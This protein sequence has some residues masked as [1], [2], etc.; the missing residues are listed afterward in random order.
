[1]TGLLYFNEVV[2]YRHETSKLY[3]MEE[4]LDHM[5]ESEIRDVRLTLA[6]ETLMY[7]KEDALEQL[8]TVEEPTEEEYLQME[9][10]MEDIEKLRS[11]SI[12]YRYAY[13]NYQS[14]YYDLM[15]GVD[16]NDMGREYPY[17]TGKMVASV[18]V[19]GV[20]ALAALCIMLYLLS[21]YL[22]SEDELRMN[23]GY[24]V[25]TVKHG[26]ANP[27]D[28]VK[29]VLESDRWSDKQPVAI[30]EILDRDKNAEYLTLVEQITKGQRFCGF[31][32]DADAMTQ[33]KA[34]KQAIL[35][36]RVNETKLRELVKIDEALRTM[37]VDVL[38][39]L[40]ITE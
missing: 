23:F 35:V 19:I 8:R 29:L 26:A 6:M 39:A 31:L 1:M 5:G 33:I 21:G 40:L 10:L 13:D 34:A 11:L 24:R 4:C 9:T 20:A 15:H 27:A 32:Q 3:T 28:S 37:N 22:H 36:A 25:S 14:R 12:S 7:G 30:L 18:I 2:A 17:L 16:E 38:G